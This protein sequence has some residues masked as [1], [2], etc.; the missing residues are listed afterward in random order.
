MPSA[1]GQFVRYGSIGMLFNGAGYLLYLV[2]TSAGIGHKLAMS[3]TYALVLLL[4]FFANR[5]ISFKHQGNAWHAGFRFLCVNI[6]GYAVNLSILL[7]F[8]D[9]LKFPHEIVQMFAIATVAILNFALLRLF[10]F[11]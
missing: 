4:G 10:V 6:V 3:V 1:L 8:V 2:V 5:K 7:L 9:K 11:V